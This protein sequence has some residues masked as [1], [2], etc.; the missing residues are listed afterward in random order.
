VSY[1]VE[2]RRLFFGLTRK[3]SG[4]WQEFFDLLNGIEIPDDFVSQ[5]QDTVPQEREGLT[6]LAEDIEFGG[7][8]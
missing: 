6:L 2:Y 4:S 8:R 5:R 1:S 3:Y 7:K